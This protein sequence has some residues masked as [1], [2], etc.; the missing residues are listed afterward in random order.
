MI[1]NN[2][3]QNIN[4]PALFSQRYLSWAI[5]LLGTERIMFATDYPYQIKQNGE[6]RHFLETAILNENDRNNIA[7][8]N[9]ERMCA[10]IKR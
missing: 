9:W 6:S 7:Y 1:G 10:A 5:E 8:A 4:N 2:F 3:N